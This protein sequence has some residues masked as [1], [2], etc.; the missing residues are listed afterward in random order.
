MLAGANIGHPC[1][2][3]TTLTALR[4][5]GM[6]AQVPSRLDLVPLGDVSPPGMLMSERTQ[7]AGVTSSHPPPKPS[8]A[9]LL[10]L[11]SPSHSQNILLLPPGWAPPPSRAHT[12]HSMDISAAGTG[13]TIRCHT[14]G[15][16]ESCPGRAAADVPELAAIE[17]KR[18]FSPC[19]PTR[20]LLQHFLAK[21]GRPGGV[22]DYL[23]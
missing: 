12:K 21:F 7:S 11:S 22:F 10:P 14:V 13:S 18:A 2:H 1:P 17:P 20:T 16:E 9:P 19:R 4:R 15:T 5:A 3:R 8:S 6:D 23:I